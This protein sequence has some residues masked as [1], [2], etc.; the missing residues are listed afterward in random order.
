MVSVLGIFYFVYFIIFL[1][2]F[3]SL[4]TLSLSI[5]TLWNLHSTMVKK[6][7]KA[8]IFQPQTIKDRSHSQSN[9]QNPNPFQ[10]SSFQWHLSV[11][12]YFCDFMFP[13]RLLDHQRLSSRWWHYRRSSTSA[14]PSTRVWWLWWC[15]GGGQWWPCLI[16][17]ASTLGLPNSS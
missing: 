1:S 10:A 7:A 15:C 16:S 12:P 8:S 3:L 17:A 5:S 4:S 2:F 13:V 14:S 11:P 6:Q 9:N